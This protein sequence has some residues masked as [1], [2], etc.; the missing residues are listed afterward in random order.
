MCRAH[1]DAALERRALRNTRMGKERS[2][3]RAETILSISKVSLL[4]LYRGEIFDK[5]EAYG[6]KHRC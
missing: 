6:G 1:S 4:L 5:L 2:R 3:H